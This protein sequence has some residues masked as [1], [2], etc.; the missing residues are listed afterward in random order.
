M[1]RAIDPRVAVAPTRYIQAL[2]SLDGP[3]QRSAG[4]VSMYTL[5]LSEALLKS[6]ETDAHVVS[7]V[8]R[9]GS[10]EEE[11]WPRLTK[12][13]LPLIRQA[14]GEVAVV[15]LVFDYDNPNHEP[16]SA[17]P[18]YLDVFSS[19]LCR[20][21]THSL[22]NAWRALYPTRNGAR[23]VYVLDHPVSPEDAEGMHRGMVSLFR[24]HGLMI[25]TGTSDWTRCMRLPYVNRDGEPTAD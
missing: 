16:W 19:H 7:Y 9:H 12:R 2:E 8:V 11:R 5:P 25:D 24:R 14:G 10:Q 18:A 23:L 21:C 1:T 13:I 22:L 20:A 17:S 3:S 4:V 6:W 15:M